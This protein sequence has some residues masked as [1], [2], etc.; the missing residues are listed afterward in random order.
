MMSALAE[1]IIAE[2]MGLPVQERAFLAEQLI[3]SL[4]LSSDESLSPAWRAEVQRRCRAIDEGNETLIP[5]NDVF[6]EIRAKF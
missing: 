6:R 3:E 2:A 4:D 1:K 5:A